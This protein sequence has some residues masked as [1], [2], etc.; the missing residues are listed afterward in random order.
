ML[1]RQVLIPRCILRA[2][3]AIL[4]LGHLLR[5]IRLQQE[6]K[7]QTV[8]AHI[9]AMAHLVALLLELLL[10]V[11]ALLTDIAGSSRPALLW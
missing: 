6:L 11:L 4:N 5:L 10:C 1:H 3:L 7:T 9:E 8:R 2:I